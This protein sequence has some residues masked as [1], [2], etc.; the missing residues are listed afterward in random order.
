MHNKMSDILKQSIAFTG[1]VDTVATIA[2]GAASL[3]KEIEQDLPQNLIDRLEPSLMGIP[4]KWGIDYLRDLD[5]KLNYS[6]SSL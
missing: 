3:S 6:L 1:D 5:A 4:S 2:L